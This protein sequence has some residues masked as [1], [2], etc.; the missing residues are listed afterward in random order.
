MRRT[1]RLLA[2]LVM[3]APTACDY[4][5]IDF[6]S[7]AGEHGVETIVIG[8]VPSAALARLAATEGGKRDPKRLSWTY[9]SDGVALPVDV[10]PL[11]FEWSPDKPP[12]KPEAAL[13]VVY[14]LRIA[15]DSSEL[16]VYTTETHFALPAERWRVLLASQIERTVSVHLRALSL[17]MAGELW[18]AATRQLQVRGPLA[19]GA[20]YFESDVGIMRARLGEAGAAALVYPSTPASDHCRAGHAVS[21]DGR[22]L[23]LA[24][25]NA[26]GGLWSL[27]ALA[28][29]RAVA[30]EPMQ[31]G[32]GAFDP[33]GTRVAQ[34]RTDALVLLDAQSGALLETLANA[35]TAQPD[36]SPDGRSIVFTL[37]PSAPAMPLDASEEPAGSSIARIEQQSDGTWSAPIVLVAAGASAGATL[38]APSY[39]PDGALIAF[40]GR[41]E[42]AEMVL[43]D[44]GLFVC[45]ANGGSAVPV[46]AVPASPDPPPPAEMMGAP[47]GPAAPAAPAN[48]KRTVG[49]QPTW[50]PGDRA[51]RAWLAFSSTREIGARKGDPK[52]RQLWIAAVDLTVP[53]GPGSEL[54]RPAFW[55]PA[56]SLENDNRRL[57][58]AAEPN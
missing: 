8:P 2:S 9:P 28:P 30:P 25:N 54:A 10:A 24:C 57:L 38:R 32:F 5:Q 15:T 18:D 31:E 4:Q 52:R 11:T 16:H 35:R 6:A 17:A 45:P 47:A 21:R 19:A 56:Q 12:K 41:D 46:A 34:A 48:P 27:P 49:S 39:S 44:V 33:T 40:E 1:L 36:W 22:Q 26:Q 29:V 20:L 7:P 13:E 50:L 37:W 23:G 55:L 58:F 53:L 3:F 42:R 14:Q 43:R 51:D